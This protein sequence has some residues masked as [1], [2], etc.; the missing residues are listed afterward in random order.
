MYPEFGEKLKD[1]F[2][3]PPKCARNCGVGP[4]GQN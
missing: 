3:I 2:V 1:K 4:P